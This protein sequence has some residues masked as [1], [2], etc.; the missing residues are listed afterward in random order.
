MKSAVAKFSEQLAREAILHREQYAYRHDSD[1][2]LY[3]LPKEQG[4]EASKW[5][6]PWTFVDEITS[7]AWEKEKI[8][9]HK[10]TPGG[11]LGWNSIQHLKVTLTKLLRFCV[12]EGMIDNEPVL[13]PVPSK[14]I[15][16]EAKKRRAL[17]PAE[18]A[19][20]LKEIIEKYPV[21]HRLYLVAFATGLRR[22]E[23]FALTLRWVDFRGGWL[24]VPPEHSKSGAEE[25]IPLHESAANA[26]RGQMPEVVDLDAPL[27]GQHDVRPAFRY[28]LKH[29]RVDEKPIDAKGL[30]AHHTTRH[31][32]ATE[33]GHS[34]RNRRAFMQVARM[35]SDAIVSRYVHDDDEQA[36][37]LIDGLS[38]HTSGH[39]EQGSR[40]D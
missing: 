21:S 36:K 33:L 6:P 23:L 13:S 31:T 25:R 20:F 1:L 35:R 4:D 40:K 15:K 22:G 27:W 7:A 28:G 18:K 37:V 34:T 2:S 8:A 11:R 10:K 5:V 14:L 32:F 38:G 12:A 19:A 3:I 16:A 39:A 29:A 26:I 24:T 30:V 9:L 17:T